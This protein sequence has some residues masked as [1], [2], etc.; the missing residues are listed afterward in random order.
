MMS[1]KEFRILKSNACTKVGRPQTKIELPTPVSFSQW[2]LSG[3]RKYQKKGA[4]FDLSNNGIVKIIWPG[5]PAILRTVADFEREYAE[6]CSKFTPI[7]TI[8]FEENAGVMA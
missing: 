3:V 5:K 8:P 1:D 2:F 7:C 6:Y 4:V